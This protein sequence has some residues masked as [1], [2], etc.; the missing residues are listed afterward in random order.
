MRMNITNKAG[1]MVSGPK[2]RKRLTHFN[3]YM[4]ALEAQQEYLMVFD[5][6]DRP[7]NI[8]YSGISY[9][10]LSQKLTYFS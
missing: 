4:F 1:K 9:F 3:G 2:M 8:S 6:A 7:T 10:L 5:Q